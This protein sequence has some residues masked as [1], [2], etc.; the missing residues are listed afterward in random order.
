MKKK[1]KTKLVDDYTGF[2]F[3]D[4]GDGTSTFESLRG[5]GLCETP[6]KGGKYKFAKVIV[7]PGKKIPKK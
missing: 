1:S 6:P 7:K 3:I 4:Q 2:N 5:K